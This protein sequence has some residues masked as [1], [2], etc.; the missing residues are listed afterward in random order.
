MRTALI[1]T[2][3]G[4][5]YTI[6]GNS[7]SKTTRPLPNCTSS[8]AVLCI[9]IF[10][11][12]SQILHVTQAVWCRPH[13]S[14]LISLDDFQRG[15]FERETSWYWRNH[16]AAP[17]G[18]RGCYI[19]I[20]YF[21]L[22]SMSSYSCKFAADRF[23]SVNSKALNYSCCHILSGLVN[24][25]SLLAL[26]VW[27]SMV[28]CMY[29]QSINLTHIFEFVVQGSICLFVCSFKRLFKNKHLQHYHYIPLINSKV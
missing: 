2:P 12:T 8:W 21:V 10:V 29:L 19:H 11:F 14:W 15:V 25:T 28:N 6:S 13:S 17:P 1:P 9:W 18:A 24:N 3:I 27:Y 5:W 7:C 4:R 23:C 20:I 16:A 22:F 26:T